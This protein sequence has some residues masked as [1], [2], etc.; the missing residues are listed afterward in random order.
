MPDDNNDLPVGTNDDNQQPQDGDTPFTPASEPEDDQATD[1]QSS[2]S[3]MDETEVYNDGA[4][5]ASTSNP[6]NSGDV[7]SYTPPTGNDD[8]PAAD[9]PAGASPAAD[10]DNKDESDNEDG[11]AADS[12]STV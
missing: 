6:A 10:A 5:A 11:S 3:N 12:G 2:D 7:A 8:A 4:A 1:S 9:A